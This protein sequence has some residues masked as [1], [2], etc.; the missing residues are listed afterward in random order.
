M[1]L[2]VQFTLLVIELLQI[3]AGLHFQT[4][5]PKLLPTLAKQVAG[6]ELT[7]ICLLRVILQILPTVKLLSLPVRE[8]LHFLETETLLRFLVANKIFLLMLQPLMLIL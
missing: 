2:V 6:E 4:V 5:L 7:G 8:I 1:Q 3:L